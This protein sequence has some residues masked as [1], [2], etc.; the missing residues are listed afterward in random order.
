MGHRDHIFGSPWWGQLR[1]GVDRGHSV[2]EG[3]GLSEHNGVSGDLC[4]SGGF[5]NISRGLDNENDVHKVSKSM[6]PLVE[7]MVS[8]DVMVVLDELMYQ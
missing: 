3:P 4:V 1:S 5:G 6:V 7:V 8:K 2:S